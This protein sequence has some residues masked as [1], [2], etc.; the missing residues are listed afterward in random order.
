[1][2]SHSQTELTREMKELN[3]GAMAARTELF[4]T[5]SRHARN[6]GVARKVSPIW[7]QLRSRVGKA[8]L[9]ALVI[10]VLVLLV[11]APGVQAKTLGQWTQADVDDSVKRGVAYIDSK[12][13]ANGSFGSGS[14]PIAE[15]GMALVAYNVLVHGDFSKL[16]AYNV[17]YPAHVRLAITWLLSQ[18]NVANGWWGDGGVYRTYGTGIVLGGTSWLQGAPGVDPGLPAAIA[19]GRNYLIN[20]DFNGTGATGCSLTTTWWCGGWSY[21]DGNRG[22]ES[23][24]SDTGFAIFGLHF[25]GGVPVTPV[26]IAGENTVWQNHI[27]TISLNPYA[28]R[29]DGGGS[30]NPFQT[31]GQDSS[32]ANDT[33]T[34][35]FSLAYDGVNVLDPHVGPGLLFA[36]DVLD[37]YELERNL[38]VGIYSMI[39]HTGATEDGSC[40]VGSTGCDWFQAPGEGGFHYSMFSLAKGIGAYN[41][42]VSLTDT[43]N[44]YAKVVD[45]LLS[46]QFADGHWP[47]DGR[48]D[49]DELLATEFSIPPLGCLGC[50]G[51]I[52]ICKSSDPNHP[53]TGSFTFTAPDFNSGPISVPVGQCSG[54]IKATAGAVTVTET[55]VLGV[56]VS[57]VTAIAYDELGFQHNELDSWTLPELH[58]IVNVMPGDEDEETLTTFTNYAAPPGEFKLCKIAA[59]QF[60]LGQVFQFTVT[61]LHTRDVYLITAGPPSQGGYCVL[62]RSFPVNTPVKIV[63]TPKFPFS[64]ISITVSEG[65]LMACQPPSLYCTIA[66]MIPGITEVSFTNALTFGHGPH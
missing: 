41:S 4:R 6:V 46:Q 1:M 16:A 27:Q 33:G 18:Q 32:N 42:T 36:D 54:S 55:P 20:K 5:V 19:N 61:T 25:S 23:D 12:Q 47:V 21:N 3:V 24:E 22:I 11:I 52:E 30:Y 2:A 44:W 15:T 14:T 35:L 48:D 66:T 7:A 59:D 38:P 37:V 45:L 64:P 31:I 62:G 40:L 34:M 60:T 53:V 49:E 10:G 43:T 9:S 13:N 8:S 58:A 17:N 65:Q 50:T 29:N 51:F 56:A 57:N 39:Y 63:E 28:T 26:N